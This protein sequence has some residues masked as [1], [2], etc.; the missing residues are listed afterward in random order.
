MEYLSVNTCNEA[1]VQKN[2]DWM[3]CKEEAMFVVGGIFTTRE[4]AEIIYDVV[5]VSEASCVS[6]AGGFFTRF[7]ALAS[8]SMAFSQSLI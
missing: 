4:N 2:L 3:A 7:H 5:C 1:A 8:P 6:S